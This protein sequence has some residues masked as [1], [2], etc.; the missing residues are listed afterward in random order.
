[1]I[2]VFEMPPIK[3][4]NENPCRDH[5]RIQEIVLFYFF[6][7]GEG[8]TMWE[9]CRKLHKIVPQVKIWICFDIIAE[10]YKN[11]RRRR[12]FEVFLDTLSVNWCW[13]HAHNPALECQVPPLPHLC[14]TLTRCAAY[15]NQKFA[16]WC[17]S[18]IASPPSPPNSTT[19]S[20]SHYSLCIWDGAIKKFTHHTIYMYIHYTL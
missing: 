6:W 10:N 19:D 14:R 15:L 12:K 2:Q 13:L 16:A 1:M 17:Y 5:Y 4:A 8:V 9:N 20:L 11:L 7:G 18:T 3:G